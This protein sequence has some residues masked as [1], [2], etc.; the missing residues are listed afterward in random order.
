M[1]RKERLAMQI[2]TLEQTN[3][4]GSCGVFAPSIHFVPWHQACLLLGPSW[5]F[6]WVACNVCS[7]MCQPVLQVCPGIIWLVKLIT[8]PAFLQLHWLQS[9]FFINTQ[10]IEWESTLLFRRGIKFCCQLL[11][12][13][14]PKCTQ[15]SADVSIA[16]FLYWK[17]ILFF[18]LGWK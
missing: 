4:L 11:N 12:L 1:S 17:W 3:S 14:P 13:Y 8:F 16:R 10:A 2:L 5:S 6:Q 18:F 7:P 15:R 9:M